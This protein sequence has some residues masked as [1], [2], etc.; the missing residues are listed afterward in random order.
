MSIFIFTQIM[1]ISPFRIYSFAGYLFR[2]NISCNGPFGGIFRRFRAK[3]SGFGQ[4]L[5]GE[6]HAANGLAAGSC[7]WLARA[8]VRLLRN[9]RSRSAY[10]GLCVFAGGGHHTCKSWTP[11]TAYGARGPYPDT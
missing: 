9:P 6:Q 1:L 7:W 2:T 4:I 5:C 11:N 10:R 8:R 3:I